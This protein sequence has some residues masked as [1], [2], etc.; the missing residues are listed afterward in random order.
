MSSGHSTGRARRRPIIEI[1]YPDVK[2]IK[3]LDGGKGNEKT[4]I[5]VTLQSDIRVR[6][7]RQNVY[8]IRM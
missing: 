1:E 4:D 7:A 3:L 6:P 2:I 8:R 5:D